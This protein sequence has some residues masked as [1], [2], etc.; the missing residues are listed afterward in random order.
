M[1]ARDPIKDHYFEANLFRARAITAGA[2]GFALILLLLGRLYYLQEISHRHYSTL[3]T[4]NRVRLMAVAPTRGLIYDRNG[5]LLADNMPT[6]RL[7]ITPE[8]VPDM[9]ATLEA[10]RD[11]VEVSDDDVTRF[12]RALRRKRPFEGVALRTNLDDADVARAAANRHRFPGVDIAARLGREYPLGDLTAHVLGYVGRIDE[13]ELRVLDANNYSGTSYVGKTGVEKYY[14]DRLHGSVGFRQV[15]VNAEGRVLR[16]LE[17][18]PPVSGN[19]LYLTIDARLQQVARDA[20]ADFSGAVVA[21]DPRNGEVLALVSQPSFDP[22]LFAEGIS[23]ADYRDLAEG[24]RRPLFNRAL[25]GQYPPGSIVKPFI[26]LAALEAGVPAARQRML[27]RGH[28]QLPNDERRY[29]DWKKQGHGL[30][31]LG[32][33]ISQSCDV[34]FYDLALRTGIDR[35][36][37]YLARFGFGELTGIDSVGEATG[38]LPSREW[39]RRER[40]QPWFP[41]ETVITGIG[42]GYLS[43]TPLQLALAT[44]TLANGGKR[45]RPRLLGGVGGPADGE[46]RVEAVDAFEFRDRAHWDEVVRSMRDVVHDPR[47]TAYWA[48]R[49]L[50]YQAAGKTGTAQVVGIAQDEEYDEEKIARR[51]RDH[52]LYVSF[53]PLEAPRIAIAVLVEHGGSGGS[54]AAPVARQVLDEYLLRDERVRAGAGAGSG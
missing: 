14:E 53:A 52:A 36:S 18:T 42:Q 9:E 20:L 35:I 19:D 32:T 33:S 10:L 44:A 39:K 12:R 40:S 4:N 49:N 16:V 54:V 41:G 45:L 7:E 22:N 24:E 11:V 34:F 27:C 29:R 31:D 37:P 13:R 46:A 26:G 28:Y 38:I 6:Y 15:E 5:V 51:L 21:L 25:S 30:V 2:V 23:L 3:S 43:A 17:E 47:G 1:A 48:H 50:R 8:S